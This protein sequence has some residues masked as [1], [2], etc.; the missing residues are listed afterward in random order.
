MDMSRAQRLQSP[1][2]WISSSIIVLFNFTETLIKIHWGF[3]AIFSYSKNVK[4]NLGPY[5]IFRLYFFPKFHFL[6]LI[7]CN[8]YLFS[9]F[10]RV[11]IQ[12]SACFNMLALFWNDGRSVCECLVVHP[13]SDPWECSPQKKKSS[14]S[15][16]KQ[17]CRSHFCDIPRLAIASLSIGQ[18]C[19]FLWLQKS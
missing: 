1:N 14:S 10:K 3:F 9:L 13:V 12:H 6:V 2:V 7:Y 4:N 11:V 17:N 15:S 19:H 8:P 5:E 18:F 16:W